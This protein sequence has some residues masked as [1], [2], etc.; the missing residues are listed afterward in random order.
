MYPIS[1]FRGSV[2]NQY[3]RIPLMYWEIPGFS[4]APGRMIREL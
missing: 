1:Y 4:H 3:G 2:E